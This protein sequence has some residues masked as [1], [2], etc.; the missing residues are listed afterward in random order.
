[1]PTIWRRSANGIATILRSTCTYDNSKANPF[2]PNPGK[3]VRQGPQ[4]NDE[5][6]GAFV[7]WMRPVNSPHE[8][9]DEIDPDEKNEK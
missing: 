4:I 8:E 9:R 7:E 3:R 5:M 6:G 1:M 2:N